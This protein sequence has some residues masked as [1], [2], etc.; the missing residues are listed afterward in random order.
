MLT[1]QAGGD[2]S[3]SCCAQ[4]LQGVHKHKGSLN[5]LNCPRA[6]PGAQLGLAVLVKSWP[7]PS[8]VHE[9]SGIS[10]GSRAWKLFRQGW[11]ISPFLSRWD[12]DPVPPHPC[13]NPSPALPNPAAC[14]NRKSS[15]LGRVFAPLGQHKL[16]H[17]GF[18]GSCPTLGRSSVTEV[19]S[20]KISSL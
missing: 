20:V 9:S 2:F 5:I 1:G 13:P 7:R 10:S 17:R 19:G 6:S 15:G 11:D 16:L 4:S 12:T 8:S 3:W 18:L 14:G